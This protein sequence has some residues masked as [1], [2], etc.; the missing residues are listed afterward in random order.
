[1]NRNLET[2]EQLLKNN[3]ADYT[4]FNDDLSLLTA[5][6]GAKQYGI[7]M[8]QCAPT[9]ILK[10][11]DTYYAAIICGHTRISF[12]KLKQAL[13]CKDISMADPATV[14]TLT[15]ANIGEVSLIN[16]T[17][18]TLIDKQVLNNQHC[19]GGCGAPKSTLRINT[20][21]LTRITNGQLL[22]FTDPRS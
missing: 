3:H 9:F 5:S 20:Q 10:S 4:I 13:N 1:M 11:K 14:T 18:I 17:L 2:L 12:K 7:T 8:Q 22:D 21:D 19:Y 16:L 15:G 6:A